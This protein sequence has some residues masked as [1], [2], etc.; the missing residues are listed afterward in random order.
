MVLKSGLE[1]VVVARP[2]LAAMVLT[3]P[4]LVTNTPAF[5]VVAL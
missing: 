3:F 5:S 2:P 1:F 4:A